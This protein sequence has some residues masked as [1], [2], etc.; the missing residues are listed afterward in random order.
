MYVCMY[1]CYVCMY[2]T[3]RIPYITHKIPSYVS[4]DI[5]YIIKYIAGIDYNPFTSIYQVGCTL[6]Y[7]PPKRSKMY[8]NWNVIIQNLGPNL[9]QPNAEA[10][11]NSSP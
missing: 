10:V 1:V 3:Q 6:K 5:P 8:E 2:V 11:C 7:D 9:P 4:G